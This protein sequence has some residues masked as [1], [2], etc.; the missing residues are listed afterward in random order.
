MSPSLGKVVGPLWFV[1]EK[2]SVKRKKGVRHWSTPP[3]QHRDHL[4]GV[5]RKYHPSLALGT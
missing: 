5:L 2:L 4:I 3:T 1:A